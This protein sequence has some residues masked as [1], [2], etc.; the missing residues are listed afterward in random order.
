MRNR[1][2]LQVLA[3]AFA[4]TSSGDQSQQK[5]ARSALDRGVQGKLNWKYSQRVDINCDGKDDLV[6]IATDNTKKYFHVGAVL[7]PVSARSQ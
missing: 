5:A 1:V 7:A 2:I 3:M 4:L 6:F